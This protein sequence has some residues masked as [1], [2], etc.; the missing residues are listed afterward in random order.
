MAMLQQISYRHRSLLYQ[1]SSPLPVGGG[2]KSGTV[3]MPADYWQ[4]FGSNQL[5]T[6]QGSS[7]AF[8]HWLPK[9]AD[10]Q[11]VRDD[12][13]GQNQQASTVVSACQ[14]TMYG[15]DLDMKRQH[16]RLA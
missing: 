5:Q 15:Y 10:H 16:L 13:I 7:M 12:C 6:V 3:S 4:T 2:P 1:A 11:N 9:R 14:H 8:M